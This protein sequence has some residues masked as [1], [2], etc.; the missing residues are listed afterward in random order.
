MKFKS[1][2][3][4]LACGD[5]ERYEVTPTIRLRLWREHSVYHVKAWNIES[6]FGLS[7]ESFKTLKA[8]RRHFL[9]SIVLLQVNQGAL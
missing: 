7:W 3:Y 2:A 4:Q 6:S 8:A 5:Y 9:A 1:S